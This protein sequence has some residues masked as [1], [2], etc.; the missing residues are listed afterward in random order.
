MAENE[1]VDRELRLLESFAYRA[2]AAGATEDDIYAAV[3]RGVQFGQECGRRSAETKDLLDAMRDGLSGPALLE[4]LNRG[5][6]PQQAR[7]AA[8]QTSRV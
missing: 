3:D 6:I 1:A 2:I 7:P 8:D 5:Q 4:M